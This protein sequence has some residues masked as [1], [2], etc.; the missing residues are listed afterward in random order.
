MFQY[1]GMGVSLWCDAGPCIGNP[2]S[3]RWDS[4]PTEV[5]EVAW[6]LKTPV[7]AGLLEGQG[8]AEVGVPLGG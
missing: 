5:R 8:V 2:E 1:A 3:H 4:G 6:F 7:V